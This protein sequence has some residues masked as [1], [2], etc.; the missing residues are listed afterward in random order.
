M[1]VGRENTIV[2]TEEKDSGSIGKIR[3]PGKKSNNDSPRH[4]DVVHCQCRTGC[5]ECY[6]KLYC[7]CPDC[8]V[9]EI[10]TGKRKKLVVEVEEEEGLERIERLEY[11]YCTVVHCREERE[12]ATK[13]EVQTQE[14]VLRRPRVSDP[15]SHRRPVSCVLAD[16][17]RRSRNRRSLPNMDILIKDKETPPITAAPRE[18]FSV[19]AVGPPRQTKY[20]CKNC[21]LD[22]CNVCFST[23][24]SPHT[25]QW[26]GTSN[27][28]C[29]SPFHKI[30]HEHKEEE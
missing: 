15:V 13:T 28:H 6:G 27:F 2:G 26:I 3:K 22:I 4:T 14:Y 9:P 23:V 16:Q 18:P 19:R 30:V 5:S 17:V 20:Y 8:Y 10:K 21:G 25:V 7:G 1:G 29:T 11:M 12:V 24:C